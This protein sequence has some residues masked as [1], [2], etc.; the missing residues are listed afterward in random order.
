M[1]ID[2]WER[3]FSYSYDAPLDMRM[4]PDGPLTAA[5][6]VN[7]WPERR[8][9]ETL[10]NLGEERHARSIARRDRAPP[11]VRDDLR[12][13]RR[14]P[15]RRAAGRPLRPRPPGEA[16]LPGDPDRRQ[17]RARLDRSRPAARLGAARRSAGGWRRSPSTRSR[18]G[19]SSASSQT[20]PGAASARR[21]YRSASAATSP[22][23]S[24]SP[25]AR[26]RRARR[27]RGK[28]T[29]ELRAPARRQKADPHGRGGGIDGS[30][31]NRTADQAGAVALTAP[32]RE[33]EDAPAWRGEDEAA[34]PRRRRAAEG[35]LPAP[36]DHPRHGLR[37]P[38]GRRRAHRGRGR[39][40]RR[41]RPRRPP[42]AQP[43]LDRGARRAPRRDRRAERLLAEPQRL[44]QPGRPEDGRAR[45]R[46]LR[47]ARPA[48]RA[49]LQ[50]G[51]PADRR[52]ARARQPDARR[53]PLSAGQRR[54]RE[55]GG[56]AAPRR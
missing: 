53:H 11:A 52:Q 51:D 32:A 49:P 36:G 6:V 34:K 19:A 22:R 42:H 47:P 18:T 39:R 55:G 17:R 1:Q 54:R 7:E 31:S 28:P 8:L 37:D 5:D 25:G 14:D 48:R 15:R 35:S 46:E 50:R 21:S 20:S 24:R 23:P 56:E 10:R 44:G 16:H 3:G 9:A 27:A 26:S 45:A 2:A 29:L 40:D 38:G 4:D 12:A 33:H 13:R 30:D 43:A 41:L